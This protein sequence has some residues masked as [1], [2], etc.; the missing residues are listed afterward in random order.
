M[1]KFDTLVDLLS[2]LVSNLNQPKKK[3][4]FI[5]QFFK[6]PFVITVLG[7]VILTFGTNWVSK[8]YQLRDKQSEAIALLESELPKELAYVKHQAM[9]LSVLEE[10]NC[11]ENPD[12]LLDKP[13]VIGL[14]GRSCQEAESEYLKYYQI[15]LNKPAGA[16]LIR[17]RSLFESP[18]I[19]EGAEIL[20]G[21][22]GLLS[23]TSNSLC[24]VNAADQARL[25]Y[26]QLIDMT[27]DE[28]DGKL[29]NK[30]PEVFDLTR[31]SEKCPKEDL[32]SAP[33][34]LSLF[35]DEKL[36]DDF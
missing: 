25:V 30:S 15:V 23:T 3:E 31:L 4:S 6:N 19:D 1:S 29:L 36:C 27:I 34:K 18:E 9:I 10:A 21:I 22:V 13:Y 17:I 24:I 12:Y 14:T 16:S 20:N 8:Q 32:C 5:S 2:E 28:V 26:D 11:D 33:G 35:V 7:G